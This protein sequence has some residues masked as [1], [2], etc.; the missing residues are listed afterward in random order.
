MKGL[1]VLFQQS[2]KNYINLSIF[3]LDIKFHC[4]SS[5]FKFLSLNGHPAA[6]E[7][8]TKSNPTN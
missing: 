5:I 3:P 4:N 7:G 6:L 8:T 2:I 1:T